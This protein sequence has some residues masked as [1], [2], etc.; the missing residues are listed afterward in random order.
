MLQ[1]P[2]VIIGL[3]GYDPDFALYC[4]DHLNK[5]SLHATI[6][7]QVGFHSNKESRKAGRGLAFIMQN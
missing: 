6:S 5:Q 1:L 7:H 3:H 2:L 4:L